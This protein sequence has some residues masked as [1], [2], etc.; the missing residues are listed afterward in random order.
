MFTEATADRIIAKD[1]ETFFSYEL[2]HKLLTVHELNPSQLVLYMAIYDRLNKRHGDPVIILD[3][4][5]EATGLNLTTVMKSV[6]VLQQKD[7]IEKWVP[8]NTNRRKSHW[9]VNK[10]V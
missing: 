2:I 9:A 1:G 4:L 10:A 6:K 7:L 8:S 5:V 3:E